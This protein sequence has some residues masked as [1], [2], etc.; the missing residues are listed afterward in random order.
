MWRVTQTLQ[1]AIRLYAA[2]KMGGGSKGAHRPQLGGGKENGGRPK[3]VED[4]VKKCLA[5]I[6]CL[7]L[8]SAST[9]KPTL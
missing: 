9:A 8:P 5:A 2:S 4:V 7:S 6:S 3:D 1:E